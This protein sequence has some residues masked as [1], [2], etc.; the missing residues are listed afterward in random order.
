MPQTEIRRPGQ[1]AALDTSTSPNSGENIRRPRPEQAP[2]DELLNEFTAATA[3]AEREDFDYLIT[4]GVPRNW[5]WCGPMR[6]GIA[7]IT[8]SGATYE[9]IVAGKRAFLLPAAPLDDDE[10]IVDLVAWHPDEPCQW[11]SRLGVAPILNPAAIDRA[12]IFREPLSLHSSP[13]AW[14][15]AG[16]EG[17]VVL[18]AS[19]DLRLHLGGIGTI[20]CDD[21]TL[22]RQIDK[23]FKSRTRLPLISVRIDAQ[24]AA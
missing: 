13:M 11:W 22:A 15:Q 17:A 12:E 7:P 1:G 8:T 2:A 4:E 9:P 19:A 20:I 16:G 10:D 23:V 3:A 21:L 24:E 14:L 18:D 6:F 5:L